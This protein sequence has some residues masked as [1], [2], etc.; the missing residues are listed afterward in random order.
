MVTKLFPFNP[1]KG[2]SNCQP[3]Q[4]NVL[5]QMQESKKFFLFLVF[6]ITTS[7][8]ASPNL[9]VTYTISHFITFTICLLHI[10]Q[11]VRQFVI[12]SRST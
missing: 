11:F 7:F 6:K 1:Y 8:T 12:K 5:Y 2:F 10:R 3:L 4:E 9:R